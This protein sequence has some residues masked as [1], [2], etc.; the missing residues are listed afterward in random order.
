[1]D[2]SGE[3]PNDS[4]QNNNK[5]SHNSKENS[6]QE[7]IDFNFE[8][9]DKSK[10]Q[11]SL[12][13][14]SEKSNNELISDLGPDE[15]V[16]DV[17][18]QFLRIKKCSVIAY[19]IKPSPEKLKFGF[20]RTCDLNLMNPICLECLY[21]CHKKYDHDIREMNEPDNIICGCGERM[22]KFKILERKNGLGADE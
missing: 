3:S 11:I 9:K 4:N 2:D 5:N 22:H 16:N 15:N 21:E 7:I 14:K 19:G 13:S 1:M 10:D 8:D 18:S 12:L 17:I 6:K 20:C